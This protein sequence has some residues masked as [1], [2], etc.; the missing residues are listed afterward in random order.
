VAGPAYAPQ[1]EGFVLQL[2]GVESGDS[3]AIPLPGAQEGGLLDGTIYDLAFDAQGRLY[4]GGRDALR[5]WV[6]EQ[7]TSE[8]LIAATRSK[9]DMGDDG[10]VLLVGTRQAPPDRT[11]VSEYSGM[12]EDLFVL[13][14]EAG[15]SRRIRTHGAAI[16]SLALGPG[17]RTIATGGYDGIVRVGPV[18]GE[19]PHLLVGHQQ[20]VGAVTIS[21]DGRWIAS[22][23]GNEIRLWPM[24]DLSKP[25]LHTLPHDE[26]MARLHTLT[27]V[28]VVEDETSPS[29]YR[30]DV[31]PFPGWEEVPEW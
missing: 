12:A 18:T 24:P 10:R 7:G 16:Q 15:G 23:A 25:P 14:L 5:R 13:D 29:G 17:A 11:G 1:P 6:L 20:K 4:S 9:L 21:P 22:G 26:L 27:N 2:W 30:L 8:V 3:R 28:R 19:E 31:G